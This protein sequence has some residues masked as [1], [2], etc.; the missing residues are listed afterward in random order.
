MANL[1]LLN[2]KIL[3]TGSNGLLGQKLVKT[4]IDDYEIMGCGLKKSPCI[5]IDKFQYTPCDITKRK[6]IQNL[7]RTF[8]PNFIIN[9]ASYTNVDGCEEEKELC[10]KVN[11]SGVENIV[12]VARRV[13]A[14]LIHISSDYVFD[15]IKGNYTEESK[16]NPL[17]F[18]GR[19]KLAS[20]NVVIIG[21]IEYAIVRTMVLYGTGKN[22]RLNFA[23]WL[24]E[25][26]L[27]G[28]PVS[29]VDDQFGHPTLADD[30]AQAIRKIVELKI[31]GVFHIVGSDYI[32][33]YH[34]AL[35]LA[36]LFNFDK[37]LIRPIKSVE[38]KQKAPRPLNSSFIMD[39]A[40]KELNIKMR[41]VEEGLKIL[42]Y[43][44][45]TSSAL[46]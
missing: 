18:Y 37:N 11:V 21:G 42:K 29:I 3:I 27:K 28:E 25:K 2:N 34:F 39:K 16:P 19:S 4:F 40:K 46:K 15:G 23:T 14:F 32:D 36:E 7:I 44:L 31:T 10:W 12:Q 26:L 17:G 6:E 22:I 9:T 38:L 13:D 30:L 8:N 20:E 5:K 24:V 43:Q 45:E 1:K 33:R 35:K 41:G